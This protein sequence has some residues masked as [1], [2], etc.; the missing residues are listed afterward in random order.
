MSKKIIL[1]VISCLMVLSLVMASCETAEEKK[2]AEDEGPAQVII[3]EKEVDVGTK[4]EVEVEA[5]FRP[6][7]EPKYGGQHVALAVAFFQQILL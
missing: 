7:D 4:Q 1:M 3:T 2:V 6:A 5:G